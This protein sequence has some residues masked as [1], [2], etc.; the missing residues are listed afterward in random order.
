MKLL[1]SYLF[2]A[3]LVLSCALSQC[4]YPCFA[5][6]Q[7]ISDVT[8]MLKLKEYV[9]DCAEALK[10]GKPLPPVPDTNWGVTEI[11]KRLDKIDKY[12]QG[13]TV[14]PQVNVPARIPMGNGFV[15]RMK[16]YVQQ[17]NDDLAVL[18]QSSTD[19]ERMGSDLKTFWVVE[20]KLQNSLDDMLRT[21]SGAAL[22]SMAGNSAFIAYHQ[23]ENDVSPKISSVNDHIKTKRGEFSAALSARQPVYA[24]DLQGLQYG[25][26]HYAQLKAALGQ[27]AGAAARNVTGVPTDAD[28]QALRQAGLLTVTSDGSGV[29]GP[30]NQLLFCSPNP[31]N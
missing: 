17:I 5:K 24:K 27:A 9:N 1:G 23:L 3:A 16:G 21:Y 15:D 8:E 20:T 4:L 22:D 13:M 10:N 25:I 26:D 14:P 12:V 30:V 31:C 19:L 2:K 29:S 18:R 11:S 6:G 7:E 28:R